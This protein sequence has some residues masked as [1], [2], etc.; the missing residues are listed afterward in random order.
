MVVRP[1]SAHSLLLW[2]FV[3][4]EIKKKRK[5]GSSVVCVDPTVIAPIQN[6]HIHRKRRVKKKLDVLCYNDNIDQNKLE[7][8]KTNRKKTNKQTRE[9]TIYSNAVGTKKK[10][11]GERN[12]A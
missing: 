2:Y 10:K 3:S 1:E 12:V 7:M 9:Q 11:K 8:Q 6:R 5:Y 4:Q